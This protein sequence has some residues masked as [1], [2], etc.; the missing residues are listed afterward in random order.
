MMGHSGH[1][2]RHNRREVVGE[3]DKVC[4]WCCPRATGSPHGGV[5]GNDS[6]EGGHWPGNLNTPERP[7]FLNGWSAEGEAKQISEREK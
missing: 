2:Q 1:C 4:G 7:C 5:G 6:E 3:R